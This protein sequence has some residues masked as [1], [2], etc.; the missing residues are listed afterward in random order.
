MNIYSYVDITKII[1]IPFHGIG[2]ICLESLTPSEPFNKICAILEVIQVQGMKLVGA[3]L[4]GIG[5]V[6]TSSM[7][8]GTVSNGTDL[9]DVCD[10]LPSEL[11]GVLDFI[12]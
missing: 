1:H 4:A 2:L 8:S 5:T 9:P 11:Q 10:S 6:G 12:G 7:S 3:L